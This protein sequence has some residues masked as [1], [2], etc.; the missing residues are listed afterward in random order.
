MTDCA[1]TTSSSSNGAGGSTERDAWLSEIGAGAM[2]IGAS[3]RGDGAA[4]G[5]AA[6]AGSV[7]FGAGDAGRRGA[8][9]AGFVGAGA[10]LALRGASA[11]AA[12]DSVT[13][14]SD[15]STVAVGD[16]SGF[17]ATCAGA[18]AGCVARTA[19]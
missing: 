8:G 14:T 9:A 18:A 19:R 13:T 3:V 12:G 10:T 17:A 1:D 5:A 7:R 2:A 16:G 4:P 11:V 6:A 15:W